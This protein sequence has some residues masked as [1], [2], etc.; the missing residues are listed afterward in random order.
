VRVEAERCIA[1]AAQAA[2]LMMK[3]AGLDGKTGMAS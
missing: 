3:E 1:S 2:R